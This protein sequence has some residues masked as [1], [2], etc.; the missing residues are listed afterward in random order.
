MPSDTATRSLP[1][2]EALRLAIDELKRKEPGFTGTTHAVSKRL[3]GVTH[4]QIE[5]LL[6]GL[7]MPWMIRVQTCD[8]LVR[9]FEPHGLQRAHFEYRDERRRAVA[10]IE[11]E[12]GIF[13]VER[14]EVATRE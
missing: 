6:E 14:L 5:N 2:V 11:R 1:R 12:V 3:N 13:S 10:A 8:E 4:R 7:T 9:F